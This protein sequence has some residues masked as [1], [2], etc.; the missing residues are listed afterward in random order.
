MFDTNRLAGSSKYLNSKFLQTL[1][2]MA[3]KVRIVGGG[4]RE[5][6]DRD[7]PGKKRWELYLT[8]VSTHNSFEGEMEM[9]LNK[10]NMG[11]L[12]SGLGKQPNA[13][14]GEEIGVFFDPDVMFGGKPVGG[15]KV[16]VFRADPFA[17]MAAA[18]APVA[19][20]DLEP[21]PF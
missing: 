19:A 21:L 7:N 8:V 6:D 12:I 4:E 9:G 15:L 18:P 5:V 20:V 17:K 11:L 13:W 3:T 10:T 2:D 16:K 1:P 14:K